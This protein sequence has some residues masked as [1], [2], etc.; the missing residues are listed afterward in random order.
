MLAEATVFDDCPASL[1]AVLGLSVMLELDGRRPPAAPSPSS[2]ILSFWARAQ[3]D[4]MPTLGFGE[5]W[6]SLCWDIKQSSC[7]WAEFGHEPDLELA[8]A[9]K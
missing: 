8:V 6:S 9:P 5:T 3:Q 7:S 2:L 4:S 1:E